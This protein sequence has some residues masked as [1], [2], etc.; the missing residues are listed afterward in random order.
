MTRFYKIPVA[1]VKYFGPVYVA[2]LLATS[3]LLTANAPSRPLAFDP[4]VRAGSPG[5]GQPFADLTASQRDFFRTGLN[6]FSEADGTDEGLGPRFNLDS[7]RGCH[8]K[9]AVGGSVDYIPLRPTSS[10]ECLLTTECGKC[11]R[12]Q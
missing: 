6:Q 1:L 10:N 11:I 3:G 12:S 2:V 4:G 5:T 9:P 7:C 8:L